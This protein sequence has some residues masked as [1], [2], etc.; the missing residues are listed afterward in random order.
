MVKKLEKH[1]PAEV[2]KDVDYLSKDKYNYFRKKTLD[3]GNE[4]VREFERS[5]ENITITLK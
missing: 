2:L 1:V 3:V 4:A 5:V